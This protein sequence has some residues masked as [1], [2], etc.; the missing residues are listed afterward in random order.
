MIL[1]DVNTLPYAVASTYDRAM[2]E[3]ALPEILHDQFAQI[4]D[5]PRKGTNV[6]KMRKYGALAVNTTPLVDGVTPAGSKLSYSDVTI[7]VRQ[8]GDFTIVTD[9]VDMTSPDPVLL[10]A[11][12]VLGEQAGQSIESVLISVLN[13]GTNVQYADVGSDGNTARTDV[14]SD[15]K[16]TATELDIAIRTMKNN[17]AKPITRVVNPDTG[18]ATTPVNSAF[19]G[20]VHPNT[21]YDLKGISG[22]SPLEDYQN[23]AQGGLRGEVGKYDRLRFVETTLAKVFSGA[24]AS[25]IDVYS[26]LIIGMNSYGISRISGEAM[27]N[28]VK[29]FGSAGSSDPLNQRATSGWKASF[30][31][32]I[33]NQLF[34]LRIEHAV[35]A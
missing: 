24:G 28:I 33:I 29:P 14:A 2:L 18:Y 6:L 1:N 25:S 7:T 10:E 32:G 11:S 21:T 4:K 30:G 19:V 26:T 16:L 15:D 34:L 23:S 3:R 17:L 20:I 27:R 35:S 22:Y 8:Y 5:L 12:E 9:W 31:A 13:A